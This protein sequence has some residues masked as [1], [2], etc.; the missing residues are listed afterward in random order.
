MPGRARP[1]HHT[2]APGQFRSDP[3][4]RHTHLR[5]QNAASARLSAALWTM[6]AYD[7]YGMP[8]G[9]YAEPENLAHQAWRVARAF[10]IYRVMPIWRQATSR[11][12]NWRSMFSLGRVLAVIWF[13]TIYWGERSAFNHSVESCRWKNWENWVYSTPPSHSIPADTSAAKRRQSASTCVRRRSPAY[14]PA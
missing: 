14:R 9:A 5:S 1:I 8:V 4:L 13:L 11:E 10:V 12:W 7:D 3:Y 2:C 6:S